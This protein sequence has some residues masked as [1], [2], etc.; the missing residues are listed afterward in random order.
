ME[1]GYTSEPSSHCSSA[2]LDLRP[3]VAKLRLIGEVIIFTTLWVT[4]I[5]WE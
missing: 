1:W 5:E 3:I 2:F 4:R